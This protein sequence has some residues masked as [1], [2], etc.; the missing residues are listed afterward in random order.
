MSQNTRQRNL[1]AAED[2]SVI[3]DS[4]KQSNFQ[5]YDYDTIRSAMVEYIRTNNPENFNDWIKSSEFVSLIELMAF[6]GHNLAFRADL[7]VR[8]NFLSTAERRESVLRIADFLG[9]KPARATPATGLLKIRSIRTNQTIYDTAGKSLKN[10][11]VKFF[12]EANTNTYQD[13]ILIMNEILDKSNR[14]GTPADSALVSGVATD[15]YALNNITGNRTVFNFRARVNGVQ[16]PFELH[17]VRIGKSLTLEEDDPDFFSRFTVVY[18]NDRQGLGSRNTGFFVAFKQGTLTFQDYAADTAIPNLT[19]DLNA[20]NINNTDVWAQTVTAAGIISD[21]WQRVEDLLG[22]SAIFNNVDGSV[23]KIFS[24][25]TR[26]NDTVSVQFADGNFGDIPRGI[27]RI[28]Y[29]Q[30]LN[31]S[32]VLNT[33]DVGEVSMNINYIG[34]DNNEYTA[35]VVLFLP[36]AVASSSASES[37]A[38]IKENASRVFYTQDRMITADDYSVYPGRTSSNIRKLK[39]VNRTHS[40]HSRFIDINDPTAQYQNVKMIS[41]DG[42]IFNQDILFRQDISFSKNLSEEQIFDLYISNL[43]NN[44]ESVNFYYKNFT[45]V[46]KPFNTFFWRQVTSEAGYSTGYLVS[47][48]TNSSEIISRVG[49]G[50]QYNFLKL[51]VVGSILEFKDTNNNTEWARIVNVYQDG[52]GIDDNQG[53]PTGLD[54]RGRGAIVLNKS[55]PNNMYVN[56]IF[57]KYNTNFTSTEKELVIDEMF[58]KNSFGIGYNYTRGSWY[59]IQP[60]N[61]A[62]LTPFSERTFSLQNAGDISG[63]NLDDSWIIRMVY[64]ETGWVVIVRRHRIVFGS[65]RNL[66]F[67][68]QNN[69]IKLNSLTNKPD[70][71]N[72]TIYS[73]NRLADNSA[74]E[75]LKLSIFSYY[76]EPS[77]FT[78]DSKLLLSIADVDNDGL[79]DNPVVLQNFIGTNTVGI[80]Q[81]EVQG[82]TTLSYDAQ[83]SIRFSG[84]DQITFQWNRIADTNQRIDPSI[85]NVIDTFVLTQSY[86]R[87]FRSWLL[88]DRRETTKPE[89][90]TADE[91]SLQFSEIDK[92]KSISDTVIY[93]SAKYKILFGDMADSVYR[94]KFRVVKSPGTTLND[95][96]IKTRVAAAIREFFDIENWDFGEPFYFTEL[97]AH[98]HNRLTGVISSVV[99]VPTQNDSVFGYLFQITPDSDELFIPDVSVDSVEIVN[100]FTET[101][102]RLRRL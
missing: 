72:I 85:S 96:E 14:F 47:A 2:F 92:K 64:T 70:Q 12:D 81:K 77:G 19:I 58:D 99:I 74:M 26:E 46:P 31:Q 84:R 71:D 1:F 100:S 86:D 63:N 25:K 10:K 55:I 6:L 22:S 34:S 95:G 98:I 28:W 23:R 89:S 65:V 59:V 27:L 29:R 37:I 78:D 68:N 66:K 18:R 93:R 79:P 9:Y 57:P 48:E 101:N 53:I 15:L 45:P 97:A 32:Y 11:T 4:F 42:Y 16:Q 80:S 52:F 88:T 49:P 21:R 91:L 40:G 51:A 39:S 24:D 61:L 76:T 82:R 20:Q 50:S 8:E 7:A 56:R 62:D 30:S 44:S 87:I 54:S 35:N 69:R 3:Y 73:I 36:E 67:Y 33:D 5:A 75:N 102:L 17:K 41:D 38:S 60:S 90:P 43:L 94:A 83:S 13:F